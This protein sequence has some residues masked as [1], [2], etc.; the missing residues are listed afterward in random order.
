MKTKNL[1]L[2]FII[3]IVL[4]TMLPRIVEAIVISSPSTR[5][6]GASASDVDSEL[7]DE[8]ESSPDYDETDPE[9]YV[10]EGKEHIHRHYNDA[11]DTRT[12]EFWTVVHSF[13]IVLDTDYSGGTPSTNDFLENVDTTTM[14]CTD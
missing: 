6:L 4:G 7:V 5:T 10:C 1:L 9:D 2:L 11:T 13:A 3:G 12:Q 8:I 14:V